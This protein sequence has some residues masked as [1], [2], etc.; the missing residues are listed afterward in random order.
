MAQKT[1]E[2]KPLVVVRVRG[3]VSAQREARETLDLLHLNHTNHAVIIDSRP[4]YKGMLQRINSLRH[5]RRTHK[6]NR[7]HD[8]TETRPLSRRQKT[9]RRIP[10]KNRLQI[11]RRPRRSHSHLQSTIQQTPR[12]TSTLP[13]ASTK[14]RLQRQNQKRLQRRR[15]SRLPRRSN[16]QTSTTHGLN[17]LRV[18]SFFVYLTF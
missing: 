16:K 4:S 6:R 12:H 8:A 13:T 2:Y 11:H 7:N 3:T 9:N 17:S 14:Q 1:E 15:R 5:L 10:H 18:P